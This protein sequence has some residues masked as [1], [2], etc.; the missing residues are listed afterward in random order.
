MAA[1]AASTPVSAR[2][3][4]SLAESSVLGGGFALAAQCRDALLGYLREPQRRRCRLFEGFCAN[5]RIAVR[6]CLRL[7]LAD[8]RP[9]LLDREPEGLRVDRRQQVAALH[10]LVIADVN[11][12]DAAGDLRRD[13]DEVGADIGVVG[14]GDDARRD[15]P[16]EK[17]DEKPGGDNGDTF[18]PTA[19]HAS[20]GCKWRRRQTARFAGHDL[21][22]CE[23]F[24]RRA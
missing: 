12:K 15:L 9:E 10:C 18:A 4:A 16:A 11:G 8:L 7:R 23:A 22:S 17:R 6:G 1:R 24:D 20:L 14:I 19:D 3:S 21:R 2:R 13:A 5:R